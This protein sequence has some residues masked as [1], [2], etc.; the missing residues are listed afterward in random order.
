LKEELLKGL[1]MLISNQ[2]QWLTPQIEEAI[3]KNF[4]NSFENSLLNSYSIYV[5]FIILI[6]V[7]L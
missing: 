3:Q 7:S 4:E 5:Q 1:V 6:K 2:L